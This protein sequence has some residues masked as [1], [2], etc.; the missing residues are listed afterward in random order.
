V[1]ALF[2]ELGLDP[3]RAA[4]S[5]S[6]RAAPPPAWPAG[7]PGDDELEDALARGLAGLFDV[8]SPLRV[9]TEGVVH[10]LSPLERSVLSGAPLAI[11]PQSIRR[12]ALVRLRVAAALASAPPP[13]TA[14]DGGAVS[15]IL[16]EIDGL[17]SAVG[18]LAPAEPP[19]LKG[20]LE[21][22]RNALVREAI[23]FSEAAQRL[24]PS[25]EVV[26]AAPRARAAAAGTRV[27]SVTRGEETGSGKRWLSVGLLVLAVAGGAAY[28]VLGVGKPGPLPPPPTVAGA[29]A[30]SVALAGS[31]MSGRPGM[32]MIRSVD[33][34]PFSA[35][36][37][38]AFSEQEL[39]KGNTVHEL[40]PGVLVVVPRETRSAR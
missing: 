13:G 38:R 36:E 2:A 22:I 15:A 19:E 28:H 37:I 34:A 16:G 29:P 21:L 31:T 9:V 18:A 17:L 30:N 11:D 7:G 5:A 8:D 20:S 33:G 25:G 12:A 4:D 26:P 40:S 35:D 24:A 39:L 3:A 14:I 1:N 27:L 23:D 10:G 6:G 32:T